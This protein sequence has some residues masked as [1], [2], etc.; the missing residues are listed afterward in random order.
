MALTQIALAKRWRCTQQAISKL[1]AKGMPLSS[2][3]AARSWKEAQQQRT[4][5][6]EIT[7]EE[8]AIRRAILELK[9]ERDRFEF[10]R[11]RDLMLA[12]AEFEAALFLTNSAILAA[13]N[14]FGP[15]INEKIEG[16]SFNDR[17]AVLEAETEALLRTIASCD[18]LEPDDDDFTSRPNARCELVSSKE[19]RRLL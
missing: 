15:R 5:R 8:R 12:V 1:V 2:E 4:S 19:R 6:T 7:D 16:L 9:L 14:A 3:A 10:E 13:L 17:A 18:Y 11:E